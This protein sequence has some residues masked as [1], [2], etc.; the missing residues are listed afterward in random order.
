MGF[1]FGGTL[2]SGYFGS[3]VGWGL[4]VYFLIFTGF[5]LLGLAGR[6]PQSQTKS[7]Q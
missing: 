6:D 2:P 7:K 3:N 1:L 4:C 5:F